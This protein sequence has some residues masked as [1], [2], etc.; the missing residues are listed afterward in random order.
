MPEAV[1][2]Q[3]LRRTATC[4]LAWTSLRDLRPRTSARGSAASAA[5]AN[6][7]ARLAA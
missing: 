1:H 7:I 2:F 6:P 5:S 4:P 3:N